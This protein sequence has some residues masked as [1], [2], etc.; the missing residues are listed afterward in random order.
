M[1][2][3]ESLKECREMILKYI[4]FTYYENQYKNFI[5]RTINND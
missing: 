5:N 3:K 1:I 2:D 4:D